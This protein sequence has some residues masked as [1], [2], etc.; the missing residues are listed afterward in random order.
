MFYRNGVTIGPVSTLSPRPLS[1]CSR[2]PKFPSPH[3]FYLP[4]ISR[5]FPVIE[6]KRSIDAVFIH[7]DARTKIHWVRFPKIGSLL[8]YRGDKHNPDCL[9]K[10]GS[11]RFV[12]LQ[13]RVGM[14]TTWT[15]NKNG[16]LELYIH[17]VMK[18]S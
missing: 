11:I 17:I 12:L 13:I 8:N 18:Y 10:L 4:R 7:K 9:G 1:N 15:Q 5:R 14:C 6:E 3:L 2:S 16:H